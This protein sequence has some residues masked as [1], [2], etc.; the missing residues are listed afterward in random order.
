MGHIRQQTSEHVVQFFE[1]PKNVKLPSQSKLC[2]FGLETS[3]GVDIQEKV[4]ESQF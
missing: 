4:V 1:V 2:C 3:F